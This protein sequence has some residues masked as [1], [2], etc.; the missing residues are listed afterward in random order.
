MNDGREY[1]VLNTGL[2]GALRLRLLHEVYGAG[3]ESLLLHIGLRPGMHVADVGCGP[4]IVTLFMAG[5]IGNT[6]SAVG[7]DSSPEQ[8]RVAREEAAKH[9]FD[10][11][12][13]IEANVYSLGLKADSFDLVYARSLLSH[14]QHPVKALKEMAAIVRPG[15]F[16]VCEDID[17]ETIYSDPPSNEYEKMVEIL[18]ALGKDRRADYS[19]GSH[20]IGMFEKLGFSEVHSKS[21]QPKF[22]SGE[23]KR[24]WEYTLYELI[25]ALERAGIATQEELN[26][27][28]KGL[29]RIG[30][31]DSCAVAQAVQTQVWARK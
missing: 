31:D 4:G 15:G 20:M 8:L 27:L 2:S 28:A 10:N 9:G 29:A 26:D 3:T 14:L 22:S 13:F 21:Y 6:G 16:L 25:P 1:Y 24:Y 30:T 5:H 12:R 18:N 7:I 19:V 17:M 11:I 23:T